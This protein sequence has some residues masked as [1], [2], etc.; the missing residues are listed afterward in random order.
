M[1]SVIVPVY[2]VQSY[3][4]QCI[5]SIQ[6]QTYDDIEILLIDDGSPDHCGE[7]CEEYAK[8]DKRI[9]VFHT[10]RACLYSTL[11]FASAIPIQA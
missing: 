4:R 5:E 6:N 8:R 2:N 9:R 3:L 10:E 7:I 11:S 1:I